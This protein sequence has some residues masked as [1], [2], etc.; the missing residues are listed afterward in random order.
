VEPKEGNNYREASMEAIDELEWRKWL[1]KELS[2]EILEIFDWKFEILWLKS[3]IKYWLLT[4][5]EALININYAWNLDININKSYITTDSCT[6][7]DS[8]TLCI[9]N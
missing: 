6:R 7:K 5:S 4:T 3:N 9:R 1:E 8:Y 2:E